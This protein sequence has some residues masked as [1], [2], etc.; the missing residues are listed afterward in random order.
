M[1]IM[2]IMTTIF[3]TI[4]LILYVFAKIVK[5][6]KTNFFKEDKNYNAFY[7]VDDEIDEDEIDDEDDYLK[8]ISKYEYEII[9]NE[10]SK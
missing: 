7:E 6:I 4:A 10:K 3:I 8:K 9:D 2:I 1:E 5:K